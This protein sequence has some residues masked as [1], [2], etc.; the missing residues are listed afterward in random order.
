MKLSKKTDSRDD[1]A[2]IRDLQLCKDSVGNYFVTASKVGDDKYHL[3]ISI[4]CPESNV[5]RE[6]WLL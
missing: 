2:A 4:K 1:E 6:K 3:N 5:R